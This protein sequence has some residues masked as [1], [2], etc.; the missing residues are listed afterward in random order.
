M[1]VLEKLTASVKEGNYYEALQMYHSIAARQVFADHVSMNLQHLGTTQTSQAKKEPRS[2][3]HPCAGRKDN[4]SG[5]AVC[6]GNGF[7]QAAL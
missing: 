4:E 6:I 3:G 5:T 2:T 7:V 1:G